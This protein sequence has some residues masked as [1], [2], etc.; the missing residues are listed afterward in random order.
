M[1][2][3]TGRAGPSAGRTAIIK[4]LLDYVVDTFYADVIAGHSSREEQYLAFFR[5]LI[6][7]TAVLVARWQCV[8]WCH[9]VCK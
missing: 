7:R 6:R 2:S 9:G 5:E 8:G 4:Q 3:I 1:D